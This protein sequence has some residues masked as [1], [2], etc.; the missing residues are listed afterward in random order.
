MWFGGVLAILYSGGSLA[1]TEEDC[2]AFSVA[3]SVSSDDGSSHTIGCIESRSQQCMK[4]SDIPTSAI[5]QRAVYIGDGCSAPAP[6]QSGRLIAAVARRGNCSFSVKMENAEKGGYSSLL[7]IG[8][9][10]RTKCERAPW[11]I[12]NILCSDN[13]DGE[14]QPPGINP[15]LFDRKLPVVMVSKK[16]AQKL[17]LLEGAEKQ[18]AHLS[19]VVA[20]E[21]VVTDVPFTLTLDVPNRGAVTLHI[22]DLE[23]PREEVHLFVETHKFQERL[24]ELTYFAI[25]KI[26]ENRK[27]LPRE[28]AWGKLPSCDH[29]ARAYLEILKRALCGLLGKDRSFDDKG[30]EH[31]FNLENRL[32]GSEWPTLAHTMVNRFDKMA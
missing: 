11:I 31:A 21:T 18:T 24:Y 9:S 22:R 32:A 30:R 12:T 4:Y 25:R 28:G 1:V 17:L 5:S 16:E 2:N 29:N 26:L 14:L 19:I 10:F 23:D 27:A 20:K 15:Q 6:V 3:C 13:Q 7:I 8:D